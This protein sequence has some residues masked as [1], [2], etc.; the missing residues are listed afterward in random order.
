MIK[1]FDKNNYE[2]NKKS[3]LGV[4]LI[5][6]FSNTTYEVKELAQFLSTHGYHTVA[7]NLPGH[8]T[9]IEEC[10]RVQYTDWLNAVKKD[11]AKLA[12][13][14]DKIYVIGCSMGGVIALYL[15]SMFPINGCVIGAPVLK[16]KNSFT[17]NY[18]NPILC[19]ILKQSKK[20]SKTNIKTKF[21]GYSSYPLI[22]LN[23]F[24]K[25]IKVVISKIHK[26]TQ[27]ILLIHSKNDKMSIKDN[28]E[29]LKKSI[30]S[31]NKNVLIVD[32]AHHNLFDENPDQDLIFNTI[33]NFIKNI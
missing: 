19:K 32:K 10:N 14:S 7:N 4:Y 3:S 27:P 33:L 23:E 20:Q 22:A 30:K 26:I 29:I 17:V 9:N 1:R 8:G 13:E 16:F 31:K 21:Y 6:G 24:K 28:I 12:S 15:A 18:L 5:H 2:F 11:V 25:L